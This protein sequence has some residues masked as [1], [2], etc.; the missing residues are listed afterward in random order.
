VHALLHLLLL[1]V[2][3]MQDAPLQHRNWFLNCR[4]GSAV[5]QMLGELR[6]GDSS[7][8]DTGDWLEPGVSTAAA[9]QRQQAPTKGDWQLRSVWCDEVARKLLLPG[10]LL[11][12]ALADTGRI[13]GLEGSRGRTNSSNSSHPAGSTAVMLD[14]N[15]GGWGRLRPGSCRPC[16]GKQQSP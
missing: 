14:L 7:F 5:L 16:C 3:H 4:A 8:S 6:S 13:E 10:L 1:L 12:P 15:R 9:A 2:Q 11:Q